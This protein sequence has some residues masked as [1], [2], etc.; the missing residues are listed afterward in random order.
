MNCEVNQ[1]DTIWYS[2]NPNDMQLAVIHGY[3]TRSYWALGISDSLV[4][5]SLKHSLCFG[6]FI[7]QQQI[8]FARVISDFSTFAYLADVFVLEGYR[9]LG[10]SKQLIANILRHKNLQGLRRFMLCT[11][12]AH[13]LYQQFGFT[14]AEQPQNLMALH[15]TTIYS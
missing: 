13:G 6:A 3:L 10:I 1:T 2:D 11:S 12:D 4:E 14:Q 8:A 15:R 9:G 5:Q 7:G